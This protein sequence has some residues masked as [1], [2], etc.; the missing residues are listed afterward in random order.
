M[1]RTAVGPW[2]CANLITTFGPIGISLGRSVVARR[3]VRPTWRG[4][5]ERSQVAEGV[6][7]RRTVHCAA[8]S[9][10]EHGPW[11]GAKDNPRPRQQ[12]SEI[13]RDHDRTPHDHRRHTPLNYLDRALR[14]WSSRLGTRRSEVSSQ[15]ASDPR[16]GASQD[17]GPRTSDEPCQ[18]RVRPDHDQHQAP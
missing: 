9:T 14:T 13:S 6:A 2:R 16:K 5:Q 4:S 18:S 1:A 15:K 17:V 8:T 7:H 11:E 12:R 10:T 3:F